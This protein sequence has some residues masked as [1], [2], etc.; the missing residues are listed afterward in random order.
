[1]G[2]TCVPSTRLQVLGTHLRRLH[3]P[4]P[5]PI[6]ALP[7]SAL[8][9]RLHLRR[10][11]R[12]LLAFLCRRRLGAV[13]R[14]AISPVAELRR[15]TSEFAWVRTARGLSMAACGSATQAGSPGS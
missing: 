1:M 7:R 8:Q 13:G 12:P 14:V 9:D 2:G 15:T 5:K 3:R 11:L 4:I 6:Q 10:H